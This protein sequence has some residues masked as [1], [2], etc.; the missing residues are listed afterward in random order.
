MPK[1]SP[2]FRGALG[3]FALWIANGTVGH[4]LLDGIDYSDLLADPSG[5]EM[6]FVIYANVTELDDEGR[7]LNPKWA[8]R[9]AAQYILQYMT[10]Q[11]ADPPLED[12]EQALPGHPPLKDSLPWPE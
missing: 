4:P 10:G 9:R 12:W 5:L 11:L 7:P 1:L 2:E 6:A 3:Q 8:E